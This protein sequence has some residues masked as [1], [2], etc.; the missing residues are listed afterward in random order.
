MRPYRK[1]GSAFPYD[2]FMAREGIPLHQAVVEVGEV[3]EGRVLG[4][5]RRGAVGVDGEAVDVVERVQL[6]QPIGRA[7]GPIEVELSQDGRRISPALIAGS[8]QS[9]EKGR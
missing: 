7:L 9:L 6:D 5:G 1:E 4:V 8:S 3:E 2:L